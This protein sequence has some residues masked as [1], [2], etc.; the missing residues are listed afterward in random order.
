MNTQFQEE[1]Y[2][3][4]L[5]FVGKMY[6][7]LLSGGLFL[8]IAL[9]VLCLVCSVLAYTKNLKKAYISGEGLNKIPHYVLMLLQ[10]LLAIAVVISGKLP[11]YA[12][13][14]PLIVAIPT[15]V[16]LFRK[17]TTGVILAISSVWISG[18]FLVM[19][20]LALVMSDKA[21]LGEYSAPAMFSVYAASDILVLR[22]IGLEMVLCIGTVYMIGYYAKARFVLMNTYR[23]ELEQLSCCDCG[24]P[25][26]SDNHFCPVCGK[27][28]QTE[29]TEVNFEAL[30][31]G[32]RCVK[33]GADL[34]SEGNCRK[35]GDTTFRK[36]F[37]EAAMQE[38]MNKAK[39]IALMILVALLIL[40]PML[41]KGVHWSLTNGLIDSEAAYVQALAAYLNE[42]EIYPDEEW[43]RSFALAHEDLYDKDMRIFDVNMRRIKQDD[44]LYYIRFSE[45]GYLREIVMEQMWNAVSENN[46]DAAMALAPTF[47]HTIHEQEGALEE[48]FLSAQGQ[49]NIFTTFIMILVNGLRFYTSF[50]SLWVLAVILTVAVVLLAVLT[51]LL[52]MRNPVIRQGAFERKAVSQAG[53]GKKKEKIT[54]ETVLAYVAVFAVFFGAFFLFSKLQKP[55]EPGF[56]D[57]LQAAVMEAGM[58]LVNVM[59]CGTE[60]NVSELAEVQLAALAKLQ[61][62]ERGEDTLG[63]Y[64]DLDALLPALEESLEALAVSGEPN[65]ELVQEYLSAQLEA[66]TIVQQIMAADALTTT[67][68]LF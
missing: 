12:G 33:C 65:S 29:S 43:Q 38:F 10:I 14:V 49:K 4:A 52:C 30:D 8:A 57:Y 22:A 5:Q 26:L 67:A 34:D 42:P 66:M 24:Y 9:L 56:H 46:D 16:Q 25:L 61:T 50:T 31:Q 32:K 13:L 51:V 39:G 2:A 58:P 63:V 44:L 55:E 68:G 7:D 18:L 11:I 27:E 6:K 1:T 45:A 35:C 62:V 20:D 48:A 47:D 17:R 21:E 54:K 64:D 19:S 15:A 40:P 59:T 3:W 23:Q 41:G 28:I 37:M 36:I 53:F 60:G